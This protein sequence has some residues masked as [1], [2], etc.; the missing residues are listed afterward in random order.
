[1][2]SLLYTVALG[3]TGLMVALLVVVHALAVATGGALS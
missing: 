3:L 2:S 1:M